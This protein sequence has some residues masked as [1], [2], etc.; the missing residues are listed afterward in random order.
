MTTLSL[1]SLWA[2]LRTSAPAETAGDFRMR[3]CHEV[4][5]LRLFAAVAGESR[6]ASIVVD[7]PERLKPQRLNRI[8]GRRL[9]V[10]AG[11]M[12]GLPSGRLAIV[13]RLCD[14]EFEDLF[15]Q[16]GADLLVGINLAPSVEAAV[17]SIARLIERWRRFLDQHRSALTAEEA[18]GLIGELAVLERLIERLGPATALAAWKAPQGSI[19]DFECAD[20]TIEAKTLLAA[21][22]GSVMINDPL[23]LKPEP[24]VPLLLACQELGRSEHPQF[25]LPGHVWRLARRFAHDIKL[26]EDFDDAL[27][28]SGYL[29][30]HANLY[31]DAYALG[32]LLAF[33]VGPDFPRIDPGSVPPGVVRVQFALEILQ[34]ARFRVEPD[35]V[36]GPPPLPLTPQP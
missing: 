18:R 17:Q 24:G 13:V 2:S 27:A 36:V 35:A 15:A 10:Q 34:L 4:H 16:L 1:P 5:D 30:A 31:T 29:P 25:T 28:A 11:D 14:P 22:G 6:D 32:P 19:R 9:S 23:Q 20:R 33:V 3:L 21:A 7:I 26:A 12:T 8:S